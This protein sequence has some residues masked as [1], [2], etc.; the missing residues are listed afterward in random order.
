M[1][2]YKQTVLSLLSIHQINICY[3]SHVAYPV[4]A[5]CLKILASEVNFYV[6][7][8]F[9]NWALSEFTQKTLSS[10]LLDLHCHTTY[11]Y[12]QY[13]NSFTQNN[14]KQTIS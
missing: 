13:I 2:L 4:E 11:L 12:Q 1:H 9:S 14:E 3:P 5:L 7:Q 8:L 10:L 6:Q